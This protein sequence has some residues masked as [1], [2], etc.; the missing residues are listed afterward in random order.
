MEEQKWHLHIHW[1]LDEYYTGTTLTRQCCKKNGSVLCEIY[2]YTTY[3]VS[4][5]L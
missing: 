3:L 4:H 2:R 1:G 5:L